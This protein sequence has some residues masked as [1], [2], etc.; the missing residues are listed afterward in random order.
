M[1]ET[2]ARRTR[3]GVRNP[4]LLALKLLNEEGILE[5]TRGGWN[6]SAV[7]GVYKR[8]R[9]AGKKEMRGRSIIPAGE[10]TPRNG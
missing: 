3:G 9:N 5:A 7:E 1:V 8:I 2:S 4:S 10:G 6:P